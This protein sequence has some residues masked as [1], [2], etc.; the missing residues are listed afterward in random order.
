METG[1]RGASHNISWICHH[2]LYFEI[3]FITE[4]KTL[5]ALKVPWSFRTKRDCDPFSQW[6]KTKMWQKPEGCYFS[7]LVYHYI[8]YSD[9]CKVYERLKVSWC[10]SPVS[11]FSKALIIYLKA[12]MMENMDIQ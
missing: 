11:I 8:C 12:M 10:K 4:R 7:A 1:L 3:N 2:L 5:G 9:P 6:D